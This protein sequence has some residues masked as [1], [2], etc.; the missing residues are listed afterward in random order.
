VILSVPGLY[1]MKKNTEHW[2]DENSKRRE[3]IW[4]KSY[5]SATVCNTNPT[6]TALGLKPG[7]SGEKLMTSLLNHGT[8]PRFQ[9]NVCAG[10]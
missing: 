10:V 1:G 6:Y 4:S 9:Q 2:G 3:T 8:N 7:I 5:P